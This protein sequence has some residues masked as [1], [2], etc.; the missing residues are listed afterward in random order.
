MLSLEAL[1]WR[2]GGGGGGGGGAQAAQ[3]HGAAIEAQTRYS[4]SS[5]FATGCSSPAYA[6]I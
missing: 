4:A 6:R 2:G 3:D 1:T 5:I